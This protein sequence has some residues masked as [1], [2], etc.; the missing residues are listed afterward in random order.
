MRMPI[1]AT[2]LSICLMSAA[3]AQSMNRTSVPHEIG[4][5]ANGF[6]YQPSP[7]EVIP[8]ERSAGVRP[9]DTK[10]AAINHDLR[11][12]DENA[13]RLEGLG[14]QNVPWFTSR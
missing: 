12:L 11:D 3:A 9:T 1:V 8:R 4:N 5:R 10:Q 6:S 14:T 7:R 13:L 2:I